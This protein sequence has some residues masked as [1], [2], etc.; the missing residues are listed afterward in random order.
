MTPSSSPTLS[1]TH[2]WALALIATLTM[3]VSYVD[4]QALAA[5]APTVTKAL[6][7]SETQFGWLVSAFSFAYLVGSPVAG[8]FIDRIGARRG[9]LGALLVWSV[10]AGLHAL[11][12]SF[13]VLLALRILLGLAESPSMPGAAQTIQ[14]VLPPASRARGFGVMFTGSSFGAIVAALLAPWFEKRWGFR[15][16]FLGTAI[17]GLVWLP[18][19]ITFAWKKSAIE[20]LDVQPT[21]KTERPSTLH[22]AKHPAVLRGM[23]A[24]VATAPA[25]GFVLN[26]GSKY[27]VAEHHVPQAEVGRFL[28]IPPLL[29]DAGSVLFGHLGSVRAR[30]QTD[31]S[32]HRLLFAA[33]TLCATALALVPYGRTPVQSMLLAGIGLAGGGG[34]FA[35]LLADVLSRVP[36]TVVSTAGGIC[37][38]AQ[39]IAYIVWAPILGKL[40]ESTHGYAVPFLVLAA[41]VLPGCL[42]W[43]LWTPPPLF[44][45]TPTA[46]GSASAGPPDPARTSPP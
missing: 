9:L 21:T 7:I 18:L 44:T 24:V 30:K 16:A 25:I 2:A 39:S 40:I 31:G 29:F 10:I 22:V 37:A 43:L 14:R 12:P 28:M 41:W 13:G 46:A 17:V 8:A 45:P 42:A 6:A 35:L 5:I 15:A 34:V 1:R 26:W 27:L 36:P 4:R 23:L 20:A 19:W 33:A 38:S 3:A 32:P 11:V